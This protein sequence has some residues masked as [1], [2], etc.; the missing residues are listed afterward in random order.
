MSVESSLRA[1]GIAEVIV[2]L[3]AVTPGSELGFSGESRSA[4]EDLGQYFTS[5]DS[6]I[7]GML[8]ATEGALAA[9]PA[10]RVYQNLG[11]VLG[12]IDESGLKGLKADK[13]VDEVHEAPELSLIKP[14]E[15]AAATV[16]VPRNVTWGIQKLGVP[17]LWNR[18]YTGKGV[19][20]GHLD[21]GVDGKHKAFLKGAIAQFAKFD[22]LGNI[23]PG[24]KATDSGTHG[25][26]TAGTILG[27]PIDG[28]EFGVAPGA[29]LISAMVIEGGHI[30]ARVLG[31]MDW[32]V[33]RGVKI[34]NM[35]L[36]LRGFDTSFLQLMQAIRSRGILPVIAVGNEGP[37]TSRSP[38]NYDLVLSVGAAS[39]ADMVALFSSSQKINRP[40][41]P[42]VPDIVGPGVDVISA[43][44]GGAFSTLSGSSMATPHIA[45]LAALL[46]EAKPDATVDEIEHA[47][48]QS[49]V[50]PPSMPQNRAN[51]GVPNALEALRL[52]NPSAAAMAPAK[53][54]KKAAGKTAASKKA[55]GKK[56]AAKKTTSKQPAGKKKAPPKAGSAAKK[57]KAKT[58]AS[59]AKR[60]GKSARK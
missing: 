48:L 55:A 13:S 5:T 6:S 32:C 26:H 37:G 41:D 46:W 9:P 7:G 34:L 44:A 43:A 31:G 40:A 45:G 52:L 39:K 35:S 24:A 36:G 25:T 59:A 54:A 19:L 18:G 38:G 57:A 49:C 23:V 22:D 4:V 3:K 15:S 14:I 2:S 27:R 16:T 33:G 29:Q 53:P 47:I 60:T 42:V 50:R 10:Y 17:E 12:T 30:V 8:A 20:V 11:L 21:T 51:R 28:V 1:F 56:P 58:P